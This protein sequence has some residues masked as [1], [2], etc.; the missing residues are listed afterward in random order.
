MSSILIDKELDND[1]IYMLNHNKNA[2]NKTLFEKSH[3]NFNHNFIKN[4]INL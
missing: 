3:D 2:F 1:W 4:K